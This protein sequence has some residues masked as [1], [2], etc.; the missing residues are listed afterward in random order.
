MRRSG[1]SRRWVGYLALWL[2]MIALRQDFWWWKDATL[3]FGSLPIGLASQ[4]GY[5]IL[6]ALVMGSLV[7]WDWPEEL[8]RLERDDRP[9]ARDRP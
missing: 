2:A 4:V 8:E 7:R 9:A 3:V 6:A 5:S 1:G